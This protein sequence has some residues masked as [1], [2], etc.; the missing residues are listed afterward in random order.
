MTGSADQAQELADLFT[1]LA[2]AVDTYRSAHY[3]ELSPQQRLDLEE[4]IQRLYDFHDEFAG[5]VIQNTID[6]MHGDLAKLTSITQRAGD[7]LRHLKSIE[8]IVSVISAAALLAEAIATG[9]YGEIPEAVR[10]LA[11]AL[12]PASDKAN[13][14]A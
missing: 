5:D 6:A 2:G 4:H 10:S 11:Q 7:A 9:A 12:Q 8:Q 13:T 14:E 1:R 3:D